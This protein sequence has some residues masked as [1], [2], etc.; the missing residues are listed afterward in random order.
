MC[1]TMHSAPIISRN[2]NDTVSILYIA[3]V[4][5]DIR[6]DSYSFFLIMMDVLQVDL[7]LP[8]TWHWFISGAWCGLQ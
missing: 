6:N 1:L 7:G 5:T 4:L 2:V 3:Y 8:A